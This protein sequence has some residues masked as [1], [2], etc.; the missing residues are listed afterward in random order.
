MKLK[1]TT[2]YSPH[3]LETVSTG[4]RQ[5]AKSQRTA[6]MTENNAE[7]ELLRRSDSLLSQM[8][9]SLQGEYRNI[10]LK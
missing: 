4:L 3:E 10:L 5:L 8:L 9:E 1:V 6:L 2:N 7:K